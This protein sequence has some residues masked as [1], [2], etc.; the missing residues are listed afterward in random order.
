MFAAGGASHSKRRGK[1][2]DPKRNPDPFSDTFQHVVVH[3]MTKCPLI[4]SVTLPKSFFS[5][6]ND[7][8]D[9]DGRRG[10]EVWSRWPKVPHLELGAHCPPGLD[11]PPPPCWSVMTCGAMQPT[12]DLRP[13]QG[14]QQALGSAEQRTFWPPSSAAR[15]PPCRNIHSFPPGVQAA[16]S[17]SAG[18]WELL[19]NTRSGSDRQ[20][21]EV[22]L[23]CGSRSSWSNSQTCG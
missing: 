19:T 1:V 15:A 16:V 12:N 3:K 5:S 10:H 20:P 8:W 9:T 11:W 13:S 21:E 6:Q 7:S 17:H 23:A 22:I 2:W 14:E 18:Q 4:L